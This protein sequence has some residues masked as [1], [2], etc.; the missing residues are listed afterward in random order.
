MNIDEFDNKIIIINNNM[1]NSLLKRINKL[2]NIKIITLSELKKKYF[3][4]YDNQTIYYVCNKY[5]VNKSIA[6]MYLENLYYIKDIDEEKIKFL[7]EL[8]N[9]LDHNKLLIYNPLFKKF[10]LNKDIVLFDLDNSSL[11]YK[12]IFDELSKN[13]NISYYSLKKDGY[14]KDL[15]KFN[16]IDDEVSFVASRICK[17]VK[18]GVDIN[19]IKLANVSEE[20]YYPIKTIFK[21]FNIPV[22]LNRKESIKGTNIVKR[23]KES[24]CS[25]INKSIEVLGDDLISKQII[26]ILSSYSFIDDYMNV[27]DLV[28][29]DI[30]ASHIKSNKLKNAVNII[31]LT[32]ELVSDD[33]YVFMLNFNDGVIPKYYKDDEYL[34]DHIRELLGISTS[35]DLNKKLTNMIINSIKRTNHLVVSYHTNG[36]KGEEYISPLY[37]KSLFE[38]QEAKLDFNDSDAFNKMNL[39]CL[40]DESNKYG[41]ISDKLLLLNNHYKDFNYM[42]YSNRF[43]GIDSKSLY[44]Y[45]GN[46]LCLSY[47]SLNTY[48]ECSFKYYLNYVLDLNKYEDSFEMI[49][50]NI[51][52][53]MLSLCFDNDF[54]FEKEWNKAIG[55]FNYPYKDSELFFLNKLKG[56]LVLIIENIKNQLKYTSLSKFMYEKEILIEIN[57][58]LHITFK[59]FIDKIMYDEFDTY[60]IAVIVDYKTG[61]PYIKINNVAYGLDMQLPIYMFLIKNSNILKNVRIGGLYLQKI[62]STE[63]DGLK[64]QGYSNSD[65]EVLSKVD[66]SY[67]DSNIIKSL[68][69]GNNGFYQYSKV[70][71]DE[72][73]D[74]I[75]NMVKEKINETS[76]NILNAN[77]SINPKKIKEENKGCTYCKYKDICYMRN[78]DIVVLN[79]IDDLFG[80]EE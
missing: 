4:D 30:D 68:K 58:D 47:T 16:N 28:F 13:N 40:K 6:K 80:G 31:D 29:D 51:F 74:I 49:I 37:S 62:L 43:T 12:N 69:V 50:G 65:I 17:L 48:N 76:N 44:D 63:E 70:L 75:S 55:K 19:N 22:N 72:Q 78:E 59:G 11:F 46:R 33:E 10:L 3:F 73:M 14:K 15:Y 5:N 45:I 79:P 23:F 2:L 41:T 38:E 60:S 7:N 53:K 36:L 66:S 24:Y 64:L 71:S 26:N 25:D 52:H 54:D 1:K 61:N 57:K 42:S 20:Y 32:N 34:N 39:I 8:K 56:D 21:M 35:Y 67:M 77:F 18:D 9:D 27:K